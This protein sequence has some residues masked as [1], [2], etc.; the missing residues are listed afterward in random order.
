MSDAGAWDSELSEPINQLIKEAPLTKPAQLWQTL[1]I[2]YFLDNCDAQHHACLNSCNSTH[3][4]CH[5]DILHPLICH[6]PWR[7]LTPEDFWAFW[8]PCRLC[9]RDPIDSAGLTSSI[10]SLATFSFFLTLTSV[11]VPS[12]TSLLGLCTSIFFALLFCASYKHNEWHH[13]SGICIKRGSEVLAEKE[14]HSSPFHGV[15]ETLNEE[16]TC[17]AIHMRTESFRWT[18]I[19]FRL[20]LSCPKFAR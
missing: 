17:I 8:K 10:P 3:A 18:H 12:F 13:S 19:K 5:L 6:A 11:C 1:Q 4:F 2:V 20:V 7:L 16:S 15:W 9:T 14:E